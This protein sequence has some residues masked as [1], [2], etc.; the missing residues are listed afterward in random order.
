MLAEEIRS[1]E[2]MGVEHLEEKGCMSEVLPE[3]YGAA[4]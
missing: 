3:I 4:L 2:S 1:R